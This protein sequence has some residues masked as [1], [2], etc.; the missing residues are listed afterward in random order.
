MKMKLLVTI[1]IICFGIIINCRAQQSFRFGGIC[2]I[3]FSRPILPESYYQLDGKQKTGFYPKVI[4]RIPM[5][6]GFW[7]QTEVGLTDNGAAIEWSNDSIH[8][9]LRESRY[10]IQF[11][12][13]LGYSVYLKHEKRLKLNLEAGPFVGYY[14]FSKDYYW[15]E[16]LYEHTIYKHKDIHNKCLEYPELHKY[17]IG[18]S[19]GTGISKDIKRATF[20]LDF[21]YDLS[22][23]KMVEDSEDLQF[24]GWERN[25]Y[26]LFSL[27]IGY[28]FGENKW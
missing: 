4:C 22:L 7:L 13:L 16:N 21:R 3:S 18:I 15:A 23:S 26:Q 8:Q 25:Y 28:I 20:L 6:K 9:K 5:K 19:V 2:G 24:G 1:S 17:I 12:E 10:F 11:T 27:S 14:L